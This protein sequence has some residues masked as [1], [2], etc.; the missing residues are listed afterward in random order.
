MTNGTQKVSIPRHNPVNAHTMGGIV[1]S[2]GL[3]ND[4][5]RQLLPGRSRPILPAFWLCGGGPR[6]YNE[7]RG[8]PPGSNAHRRRRGGREA[9]SF[10]GNLSGLLR[11]ARCG[12]QARSLKAKQSGY[13]PYR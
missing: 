6:V 13:I 11:P 10:N 12:Q 7:Q 5:F 2:A 9:V 1:R 4:E 8:R 3:T